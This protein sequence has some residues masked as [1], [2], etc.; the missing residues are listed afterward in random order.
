MSQ[1]IEPNV[2][3]GMTELGEKRFALLQALR[4]RGYALELAMQAVINTTEESIDGALAKAKNQVRSFHN[5][6]QTRPH[7]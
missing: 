5:G 3:R 1:A 2:Q 6:L 4:L 7:V